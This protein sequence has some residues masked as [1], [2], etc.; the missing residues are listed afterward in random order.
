MK[1]KLNGNAANNRMTPSYSSTSIK[2][3]FGSNSRS[4]KGIAHSRRSYG[5]HSPR[6]PYAPLVHVS[7][8]CT[9]SDEEVHIPV[10]LPHLILIGAQ[11]AGT[12]TIKTMMKQR[13]EVVCTKIPNELRFLDEEVVMKALPD[14]WLNETD[15]ERL[16]VLRKRYAEKFLWKTDGEEQKMRIAFEK[17]PSYMMRPTI[18]HAL[19]ALCP[20]KP[21][22]LVTLRNPAERA[23]SQFSMNVK[24]ELLP[25]NTTFEQ[26]VEAEIDQLIQRGFL[27]E[28][29]LSLS[30]YEKRRDEF[31]SNNVSDKNLSPFALHDVTL[32]EYAEIA[33]KVLKLTEGIRGANFMLFR[34]FYA[35][36]LLPWVETF[37]PDEQMMILRFEDLT[38]NQTDVEERILSFAGL[39]NPPI[40]DR[41]RDIKRNGFRGDAEISPITKEYLKW[42]YQPFNDLLPTLIGDEWRGV[43]DEW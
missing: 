30:E 12:G 6:P 24:Q 9:I 11:K 5:Y 1:Y 43:W 39:D 15:E 17:T 21:R 27:K 19:D 20:W 14:G 4:S 42:L 34:G 35:L 31:D 26:I 37:G 7:H 33:S 8:N 40:A 38:D 25:Q 16:C 2:H 29:T 36:Q 28:G 41:K 23:F 22:I 13:P 18:P 3:V 32:E 10:A